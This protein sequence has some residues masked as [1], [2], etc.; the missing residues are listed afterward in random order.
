MLIDS[1]NLTSRRLY[2]SYFKLHVRWLRLF[3]S[4][5]YFSKLLGINEGHSC[6]SP[7][8]SLELV[9]F[10]PDEFVTPLPRDLA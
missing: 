5:T 7:E 3:S 2:P 6:P 9:K 1:C 8:A 4:V 10:V